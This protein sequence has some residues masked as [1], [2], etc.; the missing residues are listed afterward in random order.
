MSNAQII[1]VVKAHMDGKRI[2]IRKMGSQQGFRDGKWYDVENPRWDFDS[3]DYRVAPET[4]E[5]KI[6]IKQCDK[7][8]NFTPFEVKDELRKPKEWW[9][10]DNGDGRP[11]GY[12]NPM[13]VGALGKYIH[14]REVIE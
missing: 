9:L 1:E 4:K 14:V 5:L 6:V 12:E 11:I 7:C 10:L 8:G 2:Q 3:C 13:M